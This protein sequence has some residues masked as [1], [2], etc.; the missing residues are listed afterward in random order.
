MA[1]S[2]TRRS[3]RKPTSDDKPNWR[4]AWGLSLGFPLFP[5][6]NGRWAKKVRGKLSYFGKIADDP[7][8]AKALDLWNEQKDDLLAGRTPRTKTVGVTVGELCDHFMQAKDDLLATGEITKQTRIDYFRTTTRIVDKFRK[9]RT[10]AD[11]TPDDFQALRSSLA[12]TLGHVALGNEI[13]RV[14]VVFKHGYDSGMIDQPMRYGPLF[15][16]PSKKAL[17]IDR[18]EKGERMIEAADIVRLIEAADVQMR[19]MIY[20]AVN[21]GFG[22]SDCGTLPLASLD[23]A[24]GWLDY[25]R[26]KTGI[27]RRCPLWPET[28]AALKAALEKRPAPKSDD[29]KPLAFVTKYGAPWAKDTFDNPVTK[30]FRKLLEDM[31]LHR[32]GLGFYT[33]RRVFRTIA[34]GSRDQPAINSIMGH[35]DASMAAAYRERIDDSRLR[36]VADHVREWLFPDLVSKEKADA[37]VAAQTKAVGEAERKP[38][39]VNEKSA[40]KARASGEVAGQAFQ[41]RIV[42]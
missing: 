11:L 42:G 17:R 16:R 5:H 2:N 19:A 30:E 4:I 36:V 20:L 40:R 13:Q 32:A 25:H 1:N 6:Q 33:L 26:P 15:K 3:A 9:T 27:D 38:R 8:G 28:V 31:E 41:L 29:A 10:V 21:C 37:E 18:A 39:R 12:K 34:D 7:K 24:G 35:A 14:R 22:N 23:L